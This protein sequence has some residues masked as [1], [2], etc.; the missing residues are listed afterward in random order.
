MFGFQYEDYKVSTAYFTLQTSQFTLHTANW[1]LHTAHCKLNTVN[2]TL[3]TSHCTLHNE[4]S[5]EHTVSWILNTAHYKMYTANCNL[6]TKNCISTQHCAL[7][8]TLGPN[9]QR[10]TQPSFIS[11]MNKR[12]RVIG[13]ESVRMWKGKK[14]GILTLYSLGFLDHLH[15]NCFDENYYVF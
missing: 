7:H 9:S 1:T 13:E 5:T 12:L 3:H 6:H 2:C 15:L 10:R 8:R 11:L 4:L 14:F